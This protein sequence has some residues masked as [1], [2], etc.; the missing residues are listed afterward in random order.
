MSDDKTLYTCKTR[1]TLY[2]APTG[3]KGSKPKKITGTTNKVFEAFNILLLYRNFLQAV[4]GTH[5]ENYVLKESKKFAFDY[6]ITS[7]KKEPL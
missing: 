4:G 6:A 7:G 3:K 1:W 5:F 2:N